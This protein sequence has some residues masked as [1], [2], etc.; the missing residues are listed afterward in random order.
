MILG[1][2]YGRKKMGLAK[3]DSSLAEPF[4]VLHYRST[5]E[6]F[7]KLLKIINSLELDKIIVGVSE[8]AMAFE[9]RNFI[10]ALEKQVNIT[11]EEF[12]E[13][14]TS[15]DARQLSKHKS[16]KSRR[17]REDAYAAALMLQGYLDN[18]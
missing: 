8:G 12:D 4:T 14:L 18:L 15:F 6:M 13:T 17:E 9:I 1:I 7:T 11:I 3:A 10:K 16:R 2:D 5:D